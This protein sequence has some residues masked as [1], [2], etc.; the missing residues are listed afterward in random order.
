M[1]EVNLISESSVS[2][3]FNSQLKNEISSNLESGQK[4]MFAPPQAKSNNLFH[5]TKELD[6][7]FKIL[8]TGSFWPR[9]CLESSWTGPNRLTEE[10]AF[11]MVCFCEIPLSRISNHNSRYGSFGIGLSRDWAIKK[12]LNPV[13]YFSEKNNLLDSIFNLYNKSL[14]ERRDGSRDFSAVKDM[15]RVLAFMK[16]S[17]G[18]DSETK[19]ERDF[20]QESEWRFIPDDGDHRSVLTEDEFKNE[21]AKNHANQRT[22]EK[23]LLE[24]EISD[25][26]YIFVETD[27]DLLSVINFINEK[28]PDCQE[29]K[30]NLLLT[31]IITMKKINQDF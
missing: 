28:I 24:F 8:K 19:K 27:N 2:S 11:P 20:Y 25:I 26:E 10:I 17:S 31:K 7:L 15:Q 30:R 12:G 21:K 16:M 1:L 5:F 18:I 13:L 9:Y 29:N 4:I 22:L 3:I 6:T 23:C 14:K